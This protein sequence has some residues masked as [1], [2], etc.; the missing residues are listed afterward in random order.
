MEFWINHNKNILKYIVNKT[1]VKFRLPKWGLK[2]YRE[3]PADILRPKWQIYKHVRGVRIWKS[4][5][6]FK[7]QVVC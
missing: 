1:F 2:Q 6:A 4:F 7:M 5:D 3:I